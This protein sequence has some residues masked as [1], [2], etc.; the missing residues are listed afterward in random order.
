MNF[1][2]HS[3]FT[4]RMFLWFVCGEEYRIKYWFNATVESTFCPCLR[5]SE[6]VLKWFRCIAHSDIF[7]Q[8]TW[9]QASS[10]S[11]YIMCQRVCEQEGLVSCSRTHT[12]THSHNTHGCSSAVVGKEPVTCQSRGVFLLTTWQHCNAQSE[13]E[14]TETLDDVTTSR[15]A[16]V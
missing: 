8:G 15:T 10:L 16:S 9:Q 4:P 3:F 12:H 7:I 6:N 1:S 13:D 2:K 11:I 5:C 14:I